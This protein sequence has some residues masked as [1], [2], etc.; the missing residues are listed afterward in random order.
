[1]HKGVCATDFVVCVCAV[2]ACVRVCPRACVF[3]RARCACVRVRPSV[4][5][6]AR[7]C[8]HS[9]GAIVCVC[10]LSACAFA[11]VCVAV[12]LRG[13]LGMLSWHL[14]DTKGT[15]RVLKAYSCFC[16]AVLQGFSQAHG[17]ES[18]GTRGVPRK[19]RTCVCAHIGRSCVCAV[20]T[21]SPTPSPMNKTLAPGTAG[22]AVSP[23][24]TSFLEYPRVPSVPWG[25]P[26]TT[27]STP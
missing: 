25:A 8:A 26:F 22:P 27:L 18:R 1:M 5:A 7:V 3:V 19:V 6:C 9:A 20:T 21:P 10:G 2:F 15:R 14:R 13:A 12:L 23:S 4:C 24:G 11:G 17:V 16:Q